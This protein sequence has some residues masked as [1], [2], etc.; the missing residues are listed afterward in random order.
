MRSVSERVARA[1]EHDIAESVR[2]HLDAPE[3]EGAHQDF[4]ELAVR[5][6]QLEELIAF[7]LDDLTGSG[8]LDLGQAP[9]SGEDGDLSA[10]LAGPVDD[11]DLAAGRDV[12]AQSFRDVPRAVDRELAIDDDEDS[13]RLRAGVDED[14]A[15]ADRAAAAVFRDALDLSRA[16]RGIEGVRR[17]DG[18]C[19]GGLP[20]IRA[21]HAETFMTGPGW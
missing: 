10:E 4:T 7:D 14:I 8:G 15:R 2:D 1:D 9:S 12:A 5:L 3:D 20:R 16:E 19:G 13:C 6:D 18:R 21:G 17:Q 11:D